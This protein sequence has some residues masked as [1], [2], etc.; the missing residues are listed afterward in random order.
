[1]S[2]I[3]LEVAT[4]FY[5]SFQ[6][7]NASG[8]VENYHPELQF[9]DPAFGE[10]SYDKAC[11]MW[12]MLCESARDLSIEFEIIKA[13]ENYV[14]TRWIAEYTFSKTNRL[15]KNEITARMQLRDGLIIK[16]DDDFN[17]HRW[18]KQA[19]GMKGLLL[20]GTNLF[21]NKL[22]SQTNRQLTKFMV[23]N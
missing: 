15:V 18:A 20:G 19:F 16:H 9:H 6:Q 5:F 11:A 2:S 17:L 13:E 8:M 10:L 7:K 4:K 3:A 21:K 12:K 1:M 14:E 23:K 22:Q